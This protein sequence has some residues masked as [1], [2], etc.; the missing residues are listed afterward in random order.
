[1]AL[2]SRV[3]LRAIEAERISGVGAVGLVDEVAVIV[4]Q[5]RIRG[6]IVQPRCVPGRLEDWLAR[7]IGRVRVAK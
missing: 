4:E 1:M 2:R 3:R 7:R 6:Q 5:I